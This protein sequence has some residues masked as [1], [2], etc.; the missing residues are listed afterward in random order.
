M[1]RTR[2][3][4]THDQ[5]Q[6]HGRVKVFARKVRDGSADAHEDDRRSEEEGVDEPGIAGRAEARGWPD[7]ARNEGS[8]CGCPGLRSLS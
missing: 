7:L 6:H 5:Q 1:I 2:E 8:E 4:K 3:G